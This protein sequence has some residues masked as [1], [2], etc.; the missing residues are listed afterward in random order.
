MLKLL[1]DKLLSKS[2]ELITVAVDVYSIG[3]DALV[4]TGATLNYISH[5]LFR[6]VLAVQPALELSI[7]TNR[8]VKVANNSVVGCHGEITLPISIDHKVFSVNFFGFGHALV[9]YDFW[10]SIL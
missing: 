2:E 5:E 4:D 1:I 10:L 9:Q 8:V 7:D 6:E 3:V